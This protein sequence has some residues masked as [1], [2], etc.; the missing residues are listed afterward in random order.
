MSEA[1]TILASW[2]TNSLLSRVYSSIDWWC[3]NWK[4]FTVVSF[5]FGPFSQTKIIGHAQKNIISTDAD[6]T[7][8]LW[9]RKDS[10]SSKICSSTTLRT[11]TEVLSCLKIP[12][13]RMRF[14]ASCENVVPGF[15]TSPILPFPP[16]PPDWSLHP[17]EETLLQPVLKSFITVFIF[18]R[19]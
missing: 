7:H 15:E 16:H 19:G 1:H 5:N 10:L 13:T 14:I 12:L 3:Q 17:L 11:T 18:M 4:Y 9:R 6:I 8:F 2:F